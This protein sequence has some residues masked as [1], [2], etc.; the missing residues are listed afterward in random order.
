MV[1]KTFEKLFQHL[2]IKKEDK[3]SFEH[4][5]HETG[6]SRIQRCTGNLEQELTGRT[7]KCCCKTIRKQ[8]LTWRPHVQQRQWASAD[9]LVK[10]PRMQDL[11][12]SC[13]KIAVNLPIVTTFNK[14]LDSSVRKTIYKQ[15]HV[16][17][18]TPH[19][20]KHQAT[21][22]IKTSGKCRQIHNWFSFPKVFQPSYKSIIGVCISEREYNT[23]FICVIDRQL[24]LEKRFLPSPPSL[25]VGRKKYK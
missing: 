11:E 24:L 17:Y 6:K 23:G 1:H 14:S 5:C 2:N 8:K 9:G 20:C 7:G 15:H 19:H 4:D 21:T 18:F 3:I 13:K 22:S 16:Q 25:Y 10:A 12:L